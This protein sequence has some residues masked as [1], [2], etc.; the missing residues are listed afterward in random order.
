MMV[1]EVRANSRHSC[2]TLCERVTEVS[3][4][5]AARCSRDG[6][7]VHRVAIGVEEADRDRIVAAG[8]HR[9]D[10][11]VEIAQLDRRLDRA[12]GLE[13]LGHHEDVAALDQ[14]LRLAIVDREDVAPVV[15]L[16]GVDVAEIA[17]GDQRDAGALPLEHRVQPD[18]RAVDEEIDR[19]IARAGRCAGPRGRRPAGLAGV[20]RILP[21]KVLPFAASWKT[22]SVNVPPISAET[23]KRFLLGLG[24]SGLAVPHFDRDSAAGIPP[25][26]SG[27][28]GP[29]KAVEGARRL[30]NA[31]RCWR[32]DVPPPPLRG[33]PPP[34]RGGGIRR[35]LSRSSHRRH[36]PAALAATAATMIRPVVRSL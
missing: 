23:R 22:R 6:E 21:V 20:D 33:P 27:G 17:R 15:A 35:R 1:V 29:P 24:I 26:R 5:A 9:R 4:S 16:D 25:P 14:A 2:E 10:Q 8:L 30:R 13:P 19:G 36:F 7:L 34:L 18:R 11:R 12:V 28:G 32:R 31:R 3:G